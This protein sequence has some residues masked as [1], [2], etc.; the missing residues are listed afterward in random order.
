MKQ[1]YI[2]GDEYEVSDQ[3]Y[4]EQMIM[5]FAAEFDI[6]SEK[7]RKIINSLGVE[8]KLSEKYSG[9]IFDRLY[10]ECKNAIGDRK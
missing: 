1:F 10:E 7:A 4:E 8:E 6:P 3:E 9:V 5:L 2:D